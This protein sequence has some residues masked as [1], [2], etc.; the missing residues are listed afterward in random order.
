MANRPYRSK[1]QRE[2][3]GII[4]A[5]AGLGNFLNMTELHARITYDSSYGAVRTSLRFLERAEMIEKKKSGV[6]TLLVPTQKGFDW[7]RPKQP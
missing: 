6:F 4:L 5:E 2:L 3:M 1:N 7:F